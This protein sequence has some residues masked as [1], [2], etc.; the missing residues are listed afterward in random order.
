M[1][2]LSLLDFTVGNNIS[3][4]EVGRKNYK[5]GKHELVLGYT[6]GE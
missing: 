4:F 3:K 5:Q 1:T 2:L 6:K